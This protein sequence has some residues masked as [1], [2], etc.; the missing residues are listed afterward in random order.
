MGQICSCKSVNQYQ[1]SM[2]SMYHNTGNDKLVHHAY[3]EFCDFADKSSTSLFHIDTP[4]LLC[5][6][7]N[8]LISL[9]LQN[10]DP[11]L[12]SRWFIR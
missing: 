1:S 7:L 12:L 6:L 2:H 10:T 4:I 8:C 3:K 5:K 9:A 11:L